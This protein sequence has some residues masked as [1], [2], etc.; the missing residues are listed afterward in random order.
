MTPQLEKV[1]FN[2]IIKNKRH[3]DVVK[4]FFFRNTEIQFIYNILRDYILE[5]SDI[6]V[7]K[8]RQLFEMVSLEDKEG[9]ITKDIL[10]TILQVKLDEYDEKNFIEPK[11][12][13]WILNNRLKAGA[14]DIVEETRGMES[15]SDF[16]MSV[17]KANKIKAIIEEASKTNFADDDDL[18]S[19]FD[20]PEHHVQD[21]SR[22]KVKCG[23]ETIDH[24]LGGGWDVGSL[25][26]LMAETS[27][28]KCCEYSTKLKLKDKEGNIMDMSIGD[29]FKKI[30]NR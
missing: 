18:G 12:N 26:I 13:S 1:F 28:G 21:N 22:F 5:N 17:E 19:D 27:N 29:F 9:M 10:K 15:L 2:Y 23:F 16:N 20:E 25:N 24:M 4:P 11:F 8:P 14:V 6:E 7:P 3:F 30:K